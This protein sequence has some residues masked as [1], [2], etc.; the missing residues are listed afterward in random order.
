MRMMWRISLEDRFLCYRAS[1]SEF[2]LVNTAYWDVEFLV[3]TSLLL[4]RDFRPIEWLCKKMGVP[5]DE[6]VGSGYN[7]AFPI[8]DVRGKCVML[9]VNLHENYSGTELIFYDVD[10]EDSYW[11]TKRFACYESEE[12]PNEYEI[13][14]LYAKLHWTISSLH[15]DNPH[16]DILC[17]VQ[18]RVLEWTKAQWILTYKEYSKNG[19]TTLELRRVQIPANQYAG[20]Q[21]NAAQLKDPSH[22]IAHPIVIVVKIKGQPATSFLDSG[23]L[24]TFMSTML[25]D[26]LQVERSKL[27]P[28]LTLQLAVQGSR[29]KINAHFQCQVIDETRFFNLANINYPIILGTDWMFEHSATIGF[30]Q[31][32][33]VVGSNKKLPLEGPSTSQ[34]ASSSVGIPKDESE[35]TR[36]ES[37]QSRNELEEICKELWAYACLLCQTMGETDLSPLWAINHQIPLVDENLVIPWCPSRLPK[38]FRS[39]W[40]EKRDAYI[41]SS[42]W[43]ISTSNN[44]IPLLFIPKL[45]AQ[46]HKLRVVVDLRQRNANTKKLASPLPNIDGILRLAACTKY[47]STMNGKD[48]YDQI[49]IELEDI[50]K[51]AVS[52]P[53]GNMASLVIQQGDC[54]APSIYQTLINYLF[55]VYL[56]RFMD[57][58]LD[59][60][61][62]YSDS[63]EEHVQHF[64]LIVDILVHEKLYL[65]ESK[66]NFLLARR[67]GL[68][69]MEY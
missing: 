17:W 66:L 6:I 42:R 3:S 65:S 26:Q 25:V 8:G 46:K 27:N 45:G 49:R 43:K 14:D 30:N 68:R 36:K 15:L 19:N 54:N 34:I 1:D 29:L 40:I 64:K 52:T 23:S 62:V 53:D 58:Y 41:K 60:I 56:G 61:I 63:V 12:N 51:T 57:I 67:Q 28:L 47:C 4:D 9:I 59:N 44:T 13:Q 5:A 20:I 37:E 32:R 2:L 7:R 16:F 22:R 48:A 21:R 24:G 35:E 38:K 55:S 33:V 69:A 10:P 31:A 11:F 50:W 18:K 39:R